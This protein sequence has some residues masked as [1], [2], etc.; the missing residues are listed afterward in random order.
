MFSLYFNSTIANVY[1]FTT[2]C[3]GIVEQ[4]RPN[5]IISSRS[6]KESLYG[7]MKIE[8]FDKELKGSPHGK[9]CLPT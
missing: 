4:T 5:Y 9:N 8:N 2:L 7:R 1:E 6:V 3:V